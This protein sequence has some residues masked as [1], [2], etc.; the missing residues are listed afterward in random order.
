MLTK[1][2]LVQGVATFS[3]DFFKMLQN[4]GNTKPQMV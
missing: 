3:M 2:R 4:K 1:I